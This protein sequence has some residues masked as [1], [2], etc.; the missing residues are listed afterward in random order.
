MKR[1]MS[2]AIVIGVTILISIMLFMTGRLHKVILTNGKK[3]GADVPKVIEYSID[4]SPFKKVRAFKKGATDI[5]GVGHTIVIRF[6]DL[7]GNKKEITQKFKAKIGERENIDLS[8]IANGEEDWIKY[9]S[10]KEKAVKKPV[11]NTTSDE[12]VV[13]TMEGGAI[14]QV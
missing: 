1:L 11:V 2:W 6:E 10:E 5:K 3:G 9:T 4:K 13:N 7:D 14:P 8:K 12:P